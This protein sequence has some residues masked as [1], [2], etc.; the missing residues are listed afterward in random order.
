MYRYVYTDTCTYR[1]IDICIYWYVSRL[2]LELVAGIYGCCAKY[3]CILALLNAVYGIHIC[4]LNAESGIYTLF[5]CRWRYIYVCWMQ[6]AGTCL[7]HEVYVY[8]CILEYRLWHSVV[9]IKCSRRCICILNVVGHLHVCKYTNIL[10]AA[11]MYQPTACNI[12]IYRHLRRYTCMLNAVC[13]IQ[14]CIQLFNTEGGIYMLFECSW[15]CT[16][17]LALLNAVYGIHIYMFNAVGGICICCLN[18]CGD[19]YVCWTQLAGT[20]VLHEVY[21]YTSIL[22]YSLWHSDTYIKYSRRYICIF[23]VI[24]NMHACWMQFVAFR[25]I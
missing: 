13:G 4:M 16:C 6:L 20:C 14:I 24:G 2:I 8:T 10:L 23:N 5:E 19:I 9:Y 22:E 21:M 12:H 15:R 1:Y 17:R 18:V 3:I 25:Y 7:L 11:H